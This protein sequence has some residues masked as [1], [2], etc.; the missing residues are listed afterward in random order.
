MNPRRLLTPIEAAEV[1]GVSHRHIQRL[2]HE[3]DV[4]RKSRWRFG[5]ELIDLAPLGSQRRMVRVNLAA[6]AP[7]LESAEA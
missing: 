3:A 1:L 4:N 5:R 2:I 6:V 7:G